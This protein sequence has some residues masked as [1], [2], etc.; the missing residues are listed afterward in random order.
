[1]SAGWQVGDLALCVDA[2]RVRCQCGK[3]HNNSE[4]RVVEGVALR[5]TRICEA[6]NLSVL[7]ALGG[8]RCETLCLENGTAGLSL[9][10]RK[11]RPDEHED[12]EAEF[13]ELLNRSKAPAR[14]GETA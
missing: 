4:G 13:V 10:F 5:V 3:P 11:I 9:R 6:R 14:V 2:G 8:C 7:C 12:C 1:M